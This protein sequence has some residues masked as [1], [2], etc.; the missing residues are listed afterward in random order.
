[1]TIP[2]KTCIPGDIM[3]FIMIEKPSEDD[4]NTVRKKLIEYNRPYFQ[5]AE[6]CGYAIKADDDEG[7][8]SG[9]IVFFTTGNWLQVELLWVDEKVRGKGLGSELLK[10][11]EEAGKDKG[12]VF[13]HL[14]TFSFQARPFYEKHGYRTAYIQK[15]FPNGI[16]KYH[17]EKEL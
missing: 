12:C 13:S 3:K 16:E 15:N 14:T 17:M 5:P 2:Q 6:E 10:K 1:M 9:G 11:A 7:G 8:F 4:I